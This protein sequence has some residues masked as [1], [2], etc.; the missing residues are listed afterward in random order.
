M[1]KFYRIKLYIFHKKQ[2][3]SMVSEILT[4]GVIWREEK[5]HNFYGTKLLKM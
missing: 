4:M 2:A 1:H 3:K 5:L